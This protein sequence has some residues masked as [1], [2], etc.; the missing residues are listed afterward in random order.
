[1][2]GTPMTNI[3]ERVVAYIA[4]TDPFGDRFSAHDVE[5]LSALAPCK[6]C[7]GSRIEFVD[8]GNGNV[9]E[10]PCSMCQPSSTGRL[11]GKE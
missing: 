3:I 4:E 8:G 7:G 9:L 1:M 5:Q 10:L 2:K 6:Y 11:G